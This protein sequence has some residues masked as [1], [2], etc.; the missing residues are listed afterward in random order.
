MHT[1]RKKER[2]KEKERNSE[3]LAN[4]ICNAC[5]TMGEQITFR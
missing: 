3:L 2:E 1:K 4:N 5:K